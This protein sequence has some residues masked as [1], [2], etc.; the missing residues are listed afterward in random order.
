MKRENDELKNN[1]SISEKIIKDLNSK[2]EEM[3]QTQQMM[4][5]CIFLHNFLWI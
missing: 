2:L 4:D 5:V 3:K 1:L